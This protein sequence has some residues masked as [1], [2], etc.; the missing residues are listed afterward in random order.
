[1]TSGPTQNY[2]DP[3]LGQWKPYPVLALAIRVGVVAVPPLVAVAFG[4]AAVRWAPPQRLGVNPW[5]W[6]VVEVAVA[7]VL[8]LLLVRLARRALPLGTLLRLT[9]FFPDR[10]P[11]RFALAVRRYSPDALRRRIERVRAGR[12]PS[13]ETYRHA[14]ALLDLVASIGRHDP[15]TRRHSERVQAYAALIGAEMGLSEVECAELSW[16][17][18]LHDVGKLRTPT[19]VLNTT[20]HPS[21]AD[22]RLLSE[23]P[24]QG[25][26]IAAPLA[27][28][29]G[30]WV[31]VIDQHHERW[32]GGGYP[33]GLAGTGISLGARIVAVADAFDVITS[34]RPYKRPLSASAARAEL[35]RCSGE[36]FDPEVVRA[37]LAVGLGRLQ[38]VAGPSSLLSGLPALGSVPM[39]SPTPFVGA[40]AHGSSAGV[41]AAAVSGVVATGLSLTGAAPAIGTADVVAAVASDAVAAESFPVVRGEPMTDGAP[42][43]A[44]AVPEALPSPVTAPAPAAPGVAGHGAPSFPEV[45]SKPGP[46]EPALTSSAPAPAVASEMSFSDGLADVGLVAGPGGVGVD[47]DVAGVAVAEVDVGLRPRDL[48]ASVGVGVL[49]NPLLGLDV[50]GPGLGVEVPR[51]RAGDPTA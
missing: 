5:A 16:A 30:E 33:Q 9:V 15:G 39:P 2:D 37:F 17:A 47:A 18:L 22:W 27:G 48:G 35:A 42:V 19:H 36:Q 38:R 23:H 11:S 7:T 34:A 12:A 8:L 20:G 10:A 29:L 51:S 21:A 26:E 28:W 31:N 13:D 14:A 4:L 24:A 40:A 45:A 1:M 46:A 6:L 50:G 41:V 49:G 32:D 3:T 44:E 25:L 43:V